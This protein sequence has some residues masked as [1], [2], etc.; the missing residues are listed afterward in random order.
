MGNTVLWHRPN[1]HTLL[2]FPPS[3]TSRHPRRPTL[4]P[5]LLDVH[6]RVPSLDG[7]AIDTP[8]YGGL[9]GTHCVSIFVTRHTKTCLLL[10]LLPPS[11]TVPG[12]NHFPCFSTSSSNVST[13][14]PTPQGANTHYLL[15]SATN[16]SLASPPR[17]P[18][19]V[20]SLTL[21]VAT[22]PAQALLTAG[23]STPLIIP[24]SKSEKI[25]SMSSALNRLQ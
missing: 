3:P 23:V 14:T 6:V 20:C 19:A 10:V 11:L 24:W 1:P 17:H 2:N 18:R 25:C 16:A 12:S 13:P 22:G 7:I 15:V 9:Y 4:Q 8:S 5:K 21:P